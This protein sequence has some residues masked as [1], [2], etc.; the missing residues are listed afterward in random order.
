M[1]KAMRVSKSVEDFHKASERIEESQKVI[2]ENSTIR[3]NS[4]RIMRESGYSA[5][6]ISE[7]TGL[8][9]ST[10]QKMSSS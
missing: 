3:K 6:K 9:P 2:A 7:L 4:V 10:I 5:A 8:S 1:E